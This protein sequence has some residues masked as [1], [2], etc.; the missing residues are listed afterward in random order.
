MTWTTFFKSRAVRAGSISGVIGLAAGGG[1]SY[2]MALKVYSF[3]ATAATGLINGVGQTVDI[4]ELD[5]D[6]HYKQYNASVELDNINVFLPKNLIGMIDSANKLPPECF[7]IPLGIG[8]AISLAI[9]LALTGTVGFGVYM[10]DKD[11]PLVPVLPTQTSINDDADDEAA[12]LVVVA[13]S[14]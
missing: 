12:S 14:T 11:K 6:I 13:V 8:L 9:A 5:T 2:A 10:F 4:P 7:I 3:C 1:T